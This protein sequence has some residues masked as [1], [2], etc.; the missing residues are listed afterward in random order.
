MASI[1]LS[2]SRARRCGRACAGT[3]VGSSRVGGS[4]KS[5][6]VATDISGVGKTS[7]IKEN[8]MVTITPMAEQKIKELM[9]EE[10]DT[11]GLRVYVRGGGCHGYQYGMAFETKISE[12]DSI[13]EK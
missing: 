2:G 11:V 9:Q 4:G 6:G 13:I 8:S 10:K 5:S 1:G 12:D 7:F 3:E